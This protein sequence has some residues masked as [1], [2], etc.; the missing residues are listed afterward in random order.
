[1]VPHTALIAAAFAQPNP[2]WEVGVATSYVRGGGFDGPGIAVQS[3]WS[4]NDYFA[5]VPVC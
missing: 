1:M 4:P 3:L 2:N 5:S